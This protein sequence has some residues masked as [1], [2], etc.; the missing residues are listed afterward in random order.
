MFYHIDKIDANEIKAG[1]PMISFLSFEGK[2]SS[3]DEYIRRA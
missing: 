2:I 1:A 3:D